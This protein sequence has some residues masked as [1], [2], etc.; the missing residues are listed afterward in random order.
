MSF[1]RCYVS[2]AFEVSQ[3]SPFSTAIRASKQF[4]G[5]SPPQF[6]LALAPVT[7][8]MG[9]IFL[10]FVALLL[11]PP[12][13]ALVAA[14]FQLVLLHLLCCLSGNLFSIFYSIINNR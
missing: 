11:R 8:V 10:G 3:R 6:L 4:I 5:L 13:A 14:G 9:G 1:L 7:L 12:L 2:I